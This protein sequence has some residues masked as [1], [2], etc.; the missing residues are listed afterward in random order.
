MRRWLLKQAVL[1]WCNWHRLKRGLRPRLHLR[2]GKRMNPACCPIAETLGGGGWVTRSHWYPTHPY[3]GGHRLPEF[4]SNF[5]HDVDY[6]HHPEL[7]A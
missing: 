3:Q 1:W 5:T 6:G 4:V 7:L 2:P